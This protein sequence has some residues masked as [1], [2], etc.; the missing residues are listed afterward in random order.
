MTETRNDFP[1]IIWML[2]L[3]G[4]ENAPEIVKKCVRTWEQANSDWRVVRLDEDKIKKYIDIRK[5]IRKNGENVEKSDISDIVRIKLLA[6]YG[7]VWVDSTCICQRPLDTWLHK[8]MDSGFFAFSEPAKDRE[9]A[10]WFLASRKKNYLTESWRNKYVK[11]FTDNN[12]HNQD[13]KIGNFV[14]MKLEGLFNTNKKTSQF[15]FS[16]FIKKV[17]KVYPYFVFH[18]KFYETIK[19]DP[20]AHSVWKKTPRYSADGPLEPIRNGL[21][22][23]PYPRVK[24]DVSKRKVPLYKLNWS[25]DVEEIR[26]GSLAEYIL[27]ENPYLSNV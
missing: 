10:S 1:K 26:D 8:Y 15:W 16:F 27:M 2:W 7:G 21:L 25:M 6:K 4:F 9:I 20:Q 22:D 3:Q 19:N 17:L 11:Y 5:I 14:K 24:K 23:N 13:T 12:F 18:Y